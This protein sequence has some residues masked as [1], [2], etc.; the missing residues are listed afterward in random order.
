MQSYVP[1]FLKKRACLTPNRPAIYIDERVVTFYELDDTVRKWVSF[2]RKL[3][4]AEKMPVAICMPNSLLLIQVIFALQYMGAITVFINT[5]LTE[6]EKQY[7]LQDANVQFFLIGAEEKMVRMENIHTFILTNETLPENIQPDFHEM[8]E[9]G[10]ND[11]ATI[12][13]TSGTTGKPKGVMQTY[14]NHLY[15]ALNGVLNMGLHENDRWLVQLPIFHVSGFSTL[16]KSMVYGMS[17]VLTEQKS[18]QSILET[19][20]KQKVTLLSFVAKNIQDI[21]DLRAEHFLKDVR[22]ILLGGGPV[23]DTLLE[24][25]KEADLPIY[26]TYGMTETASQVATIDG[27]DIYR[28]M[29]SVGKPLFFNQIRILGTETSNTVGE[30][31]IKGPTVMKG[32]LHQFEETHARMTTDGFFHTG[33]LGYLD[34]EGYLYIMARCSD[35]IISGGEN[36]Y[37]AEIEMRMMALMWFTEV[38]VVGHKDEKW[39][40][41]PVAFYVKKPDVEIT[42]EEIKR[43]LQTHLAKYKL[44]KMY[45]AV[46]E[47]PR[48]ALGKV[49]KNQLKKWLEHK[50]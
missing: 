12:M 22:G 16:I 32:Y 37:P 1:N 18:M 3:G 48:N 33:D 7:Q 23:S 38:A 44:P 15:S 10:I 25:C 45:Y 29:G 11:V 41:V 28:K 13:Y 40:E 31:L 24:K 42:E 30:I 19:I 20:Q 14:G 43:R 17:I 27:C 2:F 35:L 9:F 50:E 21:F 26:L 46:S 34:E 49:E 36:I 5:R 47:L 6:G 39:G 8:I 4:I